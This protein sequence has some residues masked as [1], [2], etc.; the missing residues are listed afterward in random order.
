MEE[1]WR[2]LKV[3]SFYSSLVLRPLSSSG[4][5][6]FPKRLI[7]F[8]IIFVNCK[9]YNSYI[10]LWF[11]LII[12]NIAIWSLIPMQWKDIFVHKL[13]DNQVDVVVVVLCA[14]NLNYKKII[15]T[16]Y[17]EHT[18]RFH[19]GQWDNKNNLHTS[20]VDVKTVILTNYFILF[21]LKSSKLIRWKIL[22]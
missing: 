12:Y 16:I 7:E 10:V 14:L 18:M 4:H 1:V 3:P 19:K 13:F 15:I 21:H 6:L 8:V 9:I 22:T 2:P 11:I 5:N 17:C 20:K